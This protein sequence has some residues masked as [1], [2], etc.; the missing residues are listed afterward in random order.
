LERRRLQVCV[1]LISRILHLPN[2]MCY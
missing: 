2:K 1:L